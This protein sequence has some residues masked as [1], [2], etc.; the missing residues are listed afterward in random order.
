[1]ERV[2]TSNLP[3]SSSTR[4]ASSSF[5]ISACRDNSIGRWRRQILDVRVTWLCVSPFSLFPSPLSFEREKGCLSDGLK[6]TLPS[7]PAP[8]STFSR[9]ASKANPWAPPRPTPPPPTSGPSVS[10][11]SKPQ[12]VTTPTLPKPT[13]TSLPNSRRSCMETRRLCRKFTRRRRGSL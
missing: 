5:A 12:S 11:S 10:Q 7:F 9:N 13:V 1:M 6:L 3:T 4:R 8:P 2:Q